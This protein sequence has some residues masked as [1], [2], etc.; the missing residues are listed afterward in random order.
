M[1][2][3]SM[4]FSRLHL[5]SRWPPGVQTAWLKLSAVGPA[6]HLERWRSAMIF[7]WMPS[8]SGWGTLL[9]PLLPLQGLHSML[10]TSEKSANPFSWPSV[11]QLTAK[12]AKMRS[13]WL[14]TA[15]T[16]E[17]KK[18]YNNNKKN[19]KQ[20]LIIT[21]QKGEKMT[22]FFPACSIFVNYAE[23]EEIK[24]PPC[25]TAP[26]SSQAAPM[27]VGCSVQTFNHLPF[28]SGA[29]V[30]VQPSKAA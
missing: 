19:K 3:S 25:D 13:A 17:R 1:L 23:G 14:E 18:I 11:H 15:N 24:L 7:R 6:L 26:L 9:S 5:P 8:V 16:R 2:G 29:L 30:W 21:L 12:H 28:T 10:Q 22:S 4:S 20:Q 27:P